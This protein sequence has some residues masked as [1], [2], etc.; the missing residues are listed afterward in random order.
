M[1]LPLA[2]ATTATRPL[3]W[4]RKD[5]GAVPMGRAAGA[6]GSG[7]R[8]VPA[9]TRPPV[10]APAAVTATAARRQRRVRLRR[11]MAAG[12]GGRAASA[13]WSAARASCWRKRSSSTA[14]ILPA[15]VEAERAR[16]GAPSPGEP[17]LGGPARDPQMPGHLVE[18]ELDQVVEHQHLPLGGRQAAHRRQ[19]VDHLRWQLSCLRWRG[20]PAEQAQLPLGPTQDGE[21]LVQRHPAHPGLWRLIAADPRPAGGRAGEGFLDHVLGFVE[22]TEHDEELADQAAVAGRIEGV[23]VVAYELHHSLALTGL[24]TNTPRGGRSVPPN[25]WH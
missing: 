13:P 25:R 3:T 14:D 1:T 23:K 11:R 21:R 18:R 17:A 6:A 16:E 5:A 20:E 8:S 4:A 2:V 19:H 10:S 15:V 7:G 22:V 12:S 9:T 24:G